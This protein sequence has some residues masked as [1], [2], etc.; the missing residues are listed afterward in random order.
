MLYWTSSPLP[1]TISDRRGRDCYEAKAQGEVV[2]RLGNGINNLNLLDVE[3]VL[4]SFVPVYRISMQERRHPG[5]SAL[6]LQKSADEVCWQ[7]S[8]R[9]LLCSEVLQDVGQ[10]FP[11]IHCLLVNAVRTT[12]Q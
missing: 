8:F 7:L 4:F 1:E 10:L 5:L 12:T 2:M 9:V 6:Y 11:V 3:S